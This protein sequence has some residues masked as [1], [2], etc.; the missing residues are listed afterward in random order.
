MKKRILFT[1]GS[2]KAGRHAVPYSPG[3]KIHYIVCL[4][5]SLEVEAW[6]MRLA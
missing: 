2:G 4:A 3:T 5:S 1:G 6:Q